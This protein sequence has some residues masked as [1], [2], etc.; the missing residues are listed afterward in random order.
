MT[1][2]ELSRRERK[3]VETRERLLSAAWSLYRDKGFEATTVEEITNAAD[4]AK[5]TFFNYFSSKEEMLVPLAAW[6]MELLWERI[7][8]AQGAPLSALRRIELLLNSLIEGLFPDHDLAHRTFSM[9]SRQPEEESP[10]MRLKRV[11]TDLTREAQ[12]QG[13]LRND[14]DP[15]FLSRLLMASSF[16]DPRHQPAKEEQSIQPDVETT[17][18]ILLQGLAGPQWRKK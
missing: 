4:V 9:L 10:P 17:L 2:H 5:G 1:E 13:E 7:D 3:K 16:R 11:F 6:R 12:Q 18:E 8:V 15:L 14:V